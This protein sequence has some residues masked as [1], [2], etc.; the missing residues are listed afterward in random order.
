MVLTPLHQITWARPKEVDEA[1]LELVDLGGLS[2]GFIP[3]A[4]FG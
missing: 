3:E 1:Q 4:T 2:L